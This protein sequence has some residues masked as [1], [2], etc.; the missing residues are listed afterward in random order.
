MKVYNPVFPSVWYLYWQD[1]FQQIQW[2]SEVPQAVHSP[3]V[4]SKLNFFLWS[5]YS[6][7]LST[8]LASLQK[9]SPGLRAASPVLSF[10]DQPLDPS[11]CFPGGSVGS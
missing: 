10:P 5:D 3:S 11:H 8:A 6:L 4:P 7:Y 9:P 1:W 2:L